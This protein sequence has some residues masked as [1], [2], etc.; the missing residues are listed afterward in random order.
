MC[1]AHDNVNS[2]QFVISFGIIVSYEANFH[3]IMYSMNTI[4]VHVEIA[5]LVSE[6]KIEWDLL[7]HEFFHCL[8]ATRC[9]VLILS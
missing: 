8:R 1:N 9:L 5:A 3:P 4:H 7:I 6:I 2:I